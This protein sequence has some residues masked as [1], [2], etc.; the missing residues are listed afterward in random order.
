M[1]SLRE[2]IAALANDQAELGSA[3]SARSAT[4]LDG[5]VLRAKLLGLDVAAVMLP[6]EI[7]SEER[8][9]RMNQLWD[10]LGEREALV[11]AMSR[12]SER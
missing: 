12:A 4:L 8:V 11:I 6:S 7:L 5:D 2:F 1:L 9:E 10:L 3:S